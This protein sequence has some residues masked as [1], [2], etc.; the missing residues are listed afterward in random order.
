M[1]ELVKGPKE[2]K[3]AAENH[4]RKAILREITKITDDK[5]VKYIPELKSFN[6]LVFDS[7]PSKFLP[8]GDEEGKATFS[9]AKGIDSEGEIYY[10]FWIRTSA[11]KPKE[12]HEMFNIWGE[13][14]KREGH[15]FRR[16]NNEPERSDMSKDPKKEDLVLF[17]D[18][19]EYIKDLEPDHVLTA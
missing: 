13:K 11:N 5:F 15:T 7:V 8:G 17:R 4:E 19:S 9:I 14:L 10:H 6:T 18:L 2:I 3:Q 12:I 1:T 16:G